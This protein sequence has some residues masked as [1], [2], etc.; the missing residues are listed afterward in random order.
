MSKVGER[1][2]GLRELQG[3]TQS[4]LADSIG[5]I[6]QT[7]Y[8]YETGLITNIPSDKIEK[9]A[10]LFRTTPAYLMG[11]ENGNN[12]ANETTPPVSFN[13]VR[14]PVYARV[15]A[16][17]PMEAQDDIVDWEDI[18]KDKTR[19]GR[20]FFGI[21]VEGNC[22]EPEYREGDVVIVQRQPDCESGQ[23][24]IVYVNGYDAELR[25]VVKQDSGIML[26][27]L[28]HEYTPT[29]YRYNDPDHP[30]VIVGVVAEIR[31]KKP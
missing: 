10:A 18:P 24:C 22:M 2:K 5:T 20:E 4:E 28:N 8:K 27:P 1:I 21:R 30:V 25:K 3:L 9:I 26:Q 15:H 16:G 17:I 31:R 11:W 29:L 19:G 13:A 7:V 6:K 12:I 14:I 23:D